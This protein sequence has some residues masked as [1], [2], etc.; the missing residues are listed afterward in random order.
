M[1]SNVGRHGRFGE[2]G[3]LLTPPRCA[4]YTPD[5]SSS[6]DHHP[7]NL[8]AGR[9]VLLLAEVHVYPSLPCPND[10]PLACDCRSGLMYPP[11][12]VHAS[13]FIRSSHS[14]SPP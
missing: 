6:I 2:N 5:A 4:L 12:G 10:A 11:T 1:V 14:G 8:V 7:R 9:S 3:S 13:P